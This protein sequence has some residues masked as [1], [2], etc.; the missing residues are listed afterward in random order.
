[1]RDDGRLPKM[2]LLLAFVSGAVALVYEVVFFRSLGL[3]FG[4]A[5]YAVTAV[6][7]A[8]LGGLGLGAAVGGRLL[9]RRSPLVT[10][11]AL[12]IG[13]ALF[14]YVAPF[15]FRR[16]TDA[17][18]PP[19]GERPSFVTFGLSFLVLLV[20]TTLMGATFPVL[21]RAVAAGGR[22]TARRVGWLY[23]VNTFGAVAGALLAAWVFLPRLGL[24]GTTHLAAGANVTLA[25]LALVL[26]VRAP[27]VEDR[28]RPRSTED[29]SGDRAPI[30]PGLLIGVAGAG[31][32][33]LGVQ[34]LGTRLLISLLGGTV[35]SFAAVLATFLLGLAIG[36]AAFGGWLARRPSPAAALARAVML[37]GAGVGVGMILLRLRLTEDPFAGPLNME[38]PA[39]ARTPFG[40][41]RLAVELS[42][43][44]L[45]PACVVSGAILPAAAR[46][47][48]G[49]G[50]A[51]GLGTLYGLNTVGAVVGTL[52]A[53][54]VMLPLLGLRGGMI[55]LGGLALAFAAFP[56]VTARR[57]G[58][59][60]DGA[61]TALAF[62]STVGA[63]ALGLRTEPPA[64]G[65]DFERIFHTESANS[66]VTVGVVHEDGESEP[67]R[68]L[69]VNGK[70]VATSVFID[71]RL[72]LL[73]G[74]LPTFLHEDP[75]RIVS[76]ALGTG[77]SSGALAMSGAEVDVVE[78]SRGVIEACPRF[79]RWTGA[80]LERENVDVIHDDGRAFLRRTDRTYDILSTDPIHP[81]VAGSAYLFTVEYYRLARS[82]LREGG[83]VSQWIPLYQLSTEDI[84]GITRSFTE[85]FP[86]VSAWV[87]GYDMILLGSDREL[88]LEPG[89]VRE[90]M[91][92]PEVRALLAEIGV[93]EPADVLGTWFAGNRTLEALA[94]EA[95]GPITDDRPWIEFTAPRSVFGG[96]ANDV[97]RRL[98]TADE[99]P[100]IAE[101]TW[102]VDREAILA[103]RERLRSAALEFVA[104]VERTGRYGQARHDYTRVLRVPAPAT[105]AKEDS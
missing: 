53:G 86:H 1:M 55:A 90:R 87:T 9:A 3:L 92:A 37:L 4:V 68:C 58:E 14:G 59:R 50:V 7:C 98:A 28:P 76:V 44:A 100:P 25:V 5:V 105:A 63:L 81:W 22:D 47:L 89:R 2:L 78:L 40:Y 6:V 33:A 13:V 71:R 42:A 67:V 70:S 54:L 35:H 84:A 51:R 32:V 56:F 104:T 60:L 34:V 17:V 8:F 88:R 83:I 64:D 82:R 101:G 23:G 69:F 26:W 94:D 27:A 85:V 97:I 77:M 99:P 21:G 43:A 80:V 93:A 31:F 10:Y 49:L 11:A 95:R 18:V 96:F 45:L 79:D 24:L 65:D 15:L 102:A 52:L 38:T 73:L 41:F 12:E 103:A 91:A 16:L 30:P 66:S 46:T 75:R 74:F 48:R 72:Q 61:K 19:P 62:A 20:P 39:W 29:G 36:G 57:A